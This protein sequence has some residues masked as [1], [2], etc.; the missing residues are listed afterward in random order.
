MIA[1]DFT[2]PAR[3]PKSRPFLCGFCQPAALQNAK[4]RPAASFYGS[5]GRQ[6]SIFD[7]CS[8]QIDFL[9]FQINHKSLSLSG[10]RNAEL[11]CFLAG[12]G[13]IVCG[14][15]GSGKFRQTVN[16]F[17]LNEGY[18]LVLVQLK[19]YIADFQCKHLFIA[20]VVES[21]LLALDVY[22]RNHKAIRIL[23]F[24]DPAIALQRQINCIFTN[25]VT[26][27]FAA[28]AGGQQ[29]GCVATASAA[30]PLRKLRRDT[31]YPIKNPS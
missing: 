24:V 11:Q 2:F 26:I 3:M 28:T 27:A 16:R 30:A 14:L 15:V 29:T 12:N 5:A 18:M 4:S 9:V 13:C 19:F 23:L 6:E 17:A 10:Q 25:G 31:S 1:L 7:L 8:F 21:A 20:L 22:F